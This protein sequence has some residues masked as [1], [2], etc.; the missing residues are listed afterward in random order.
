MSSSET[1]TSDENALTA[2]DALE[3]AW[4]WF[5]LHAN[6]RLTVI[7]YALLVAGGLAVGISYLDQEEHFFFCLLLCIFASVVTYGFLK[8][9]SRTND[10]VKV[11][12]RALVPIEATLAEITG[13]ASMNIC[14]AANEE[15]RF[16]YTY[17]DCVKLMLWSLI[18]LYA[19]A[20]VHFIVKLFGG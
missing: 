7:R 8:L 4:F 17:G 5:Q 16:P 18:V 3:H 2:R 12:E 1:D 11:G 19:V 6:Q 15:L 20:F 9:D 13:N 10:L 14:T